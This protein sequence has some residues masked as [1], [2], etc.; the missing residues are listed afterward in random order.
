MQNLSSEPLD[1]ILKQYPYTVT[2]IRLESYKGKKGV[3]WIET[4]EGTKILKKHPNSETMLLFLLEAISHLQKRGIHIP[5]VFLTK[6]GNPY[7]KIGETCYILIKA[8][9]GVNPNYKKPDQ[10]EAL[11]R[12]LGRFHRA[13]VGFVPPQ[14]SK[15]RQHLGNW[16]Q[17]YSATRDQLLDFYTQEKNRA[18]HGAFGEIILSEFPYFLDRMEKALSGLTESPLYAQWVEKVEAK[19]GLCHQDFAAGNILLNPSG[20]AYVLD[21]DSLTIDLPARDIRKLLNKVM[22]KSGGWNAKQVRNILG[23]Y[24]EENP[25]TADEWAVVKLDL[26][27]PHLFVGIMDKYYRRREKE[28]SEEKYLRRLKEMIGVEKSL[29]PIME[30][31][32]QMIDEI[33]DAP[34]RAHD[35][36]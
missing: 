23:W 30:K 2:G 31:Y 27:F 21:T 12:E 10:L 5:K 20:K 11:V 6:E 25:L 9:E 15:V 24:Q 8:V 17:D 16:V 18:A 13:S 1:Q 36:K 33:L 22:K 3:W 4:T 29:D 26:L 19:G 28:W 32:D 14:G 7:V 35:I 34:D